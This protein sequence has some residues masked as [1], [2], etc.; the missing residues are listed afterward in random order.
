MAEFQAKK[1]PGSFDPWPRRSTGAKSQ[2]RTKVET[3]QVPDHKPDRQ[4]LDEARWVRNLPEDLSREEWLRRGAPKP[5]PDYRLPY[6]ACWACGAR[7]QKRDSP[8][9]HQPNAVVCYG[10]GVPGKTKTTCPTCSEL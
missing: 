4:M 1:M 8:D 5:R 2:Q 6:K 9:C 3:L 7:G 10:C